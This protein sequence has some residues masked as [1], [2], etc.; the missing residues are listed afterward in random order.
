M[1]YGTGSSQALLSDLTLSYLAD[2]EQYLVNFSYGG[3]LFPSSSTSALSG[4]IG[5]PMAAPGVVAAKSL[6]PG[7]PLYGRGAGCGFLTG[8]PAIAWPPAYTCSAAGTYGCSPDN[9]M[10]SVCIINGNYNT[11]PAIISMYI[12]ASTGTL[13]NGMT[14][15]N[16]PGVPSA[17][18]FFSSAQAVVASGVASAT[19]SS[20]GGFSNALDFVPVQVGFWSCNQ[21]LSSTSN[22]SVGAESS[23]ASLN[24]FA[25]LFG[26]TTDMASFAGQARCSKCVREDRAASCLVFCA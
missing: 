23:G 16:A 2:T 3:L 11:E 9:R 7:W 17:F 18:A 26:V 15:L 12:N 14:N 21:L 1:S 8:P 22:T 13:N 10:S 5:V 20:T 4:N 25:S 6:S 24:A 19:A